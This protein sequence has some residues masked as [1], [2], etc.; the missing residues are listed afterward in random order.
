ML[1][2]L[3]REIIPGAACVSDCRKS[4]APHRA[5]ESL[6]ICHKS[7]LLMLELSCCSSSKL[8]E[9]FENAF[10][11]LVAIHDTAASQI[12]RRQFHRNLVPRQNT[13]EILAHLSG[14]MR[15]HL[16]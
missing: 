16:V 12:V 10:Y 2:L 3:T 1:F 11:L 4:P 15:E 8:P 14:N 13:N 9:T 5:G 7:F 6:C